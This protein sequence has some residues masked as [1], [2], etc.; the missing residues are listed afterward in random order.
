MIEE[1]QPVPF[2]VTDGSHCEDFFSAFMH[3]L[4]LAA[5]Y[6]N[7]DAIVTWRKNKINNGES[8]SLKYV[9]DAV[10]Y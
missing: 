8:T 1:T 6:G 7:I 3:D 5:E 9:R 10:R 4:L 2:P